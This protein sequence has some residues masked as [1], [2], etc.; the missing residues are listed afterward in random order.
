M[1][2]LSFLTVKI[3]LRGIIYQGD[4]LLENERQARHLARNLAAFRDGSW[5]RWNELRVVEE[6]FFAVAV[7]TALRWLASAEGSD[8][9]LSQPAD[10]FRSAV[11]DAVELRDMREHADE[12][13]QGRGKHPGRIVRTIATPEDPNAMACDATGSLSS[14]CAV[15]RAALAARM[16][17]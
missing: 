12:Y 2:L 13:L 10:E 4:R 15:F 6:H 8:P 16:G 3:W 1:E 11:P 17:S 7:R 9:S 5:Q 14:T